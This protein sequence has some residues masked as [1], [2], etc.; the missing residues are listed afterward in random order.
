MREPSVGETK[1]TVPIA[2]SAVTI[3][4]AKRGLRCVSLPRSGPREHM[5]YAAIDSERS[6]KI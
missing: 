3:A 5:D 1:G 6:K 4:G 2:C